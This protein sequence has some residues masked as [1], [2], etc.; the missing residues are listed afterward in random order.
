[1]AA[2]KPAR[3]EK[4]F[5]L[6]VDIGGT[7]TDVVLRRADGK[8]W[9]DKVLTTHHDLLE[10]LFRGVEQVLRKAK[11]G[12]AQVDDVV[13]HATTV[14]TNALIER[15][16]PKTALLTTNG[17]RD[18]LYIRDEYRYDMYDPQIEFPP[19][20][21]PHE[22]TFGVAE[23]TRA[24][25]T[26][27]KE[28]D[29]TE[30]RALAQTLRE[31]GVISV[32][33]CFL[34]AYRNPQN[35]RV[36][37]AA[38]RESAPELYVSLSSDVSPQIREYPRT[39]TTVIN[40]Y[41]APIAGPYLTRMAA[42]LRERGFVNAP[43][44]MLSNGGVIGVSVAGRFPVRMIESGPAAGALAASYYADTL[45][46]DRLL[47]FDMG[48][49]TAKACL[50]EN[51]APFVSGFFEVDRKYRFK[52]GSGY[53]VTIPSVDMIEIGA[54]G[55]SI[56]T[57]D[58]LNLLKVGPQ[59][60]GSMPGPVCYGHGGQDICVTDADLAL[61]LLDADHFLGGEMKLDVG[62][63]RARLTTL[64]GELGV[65]PADA[66]AGIYRIVGETMASAARAHAV[67][68]GVDYRGIPLLAFGGAGPLHACYVAGLLGSTTVIVPPN[69]SVLSAFGMLVTPVRYDLVRGA[70]GKLE[71]IDWSV[72]DSTFE[73]MTTAGR[74]ALL[75][76]GVPGGE[77][78][79]SFGGDLRYYGQAHEVTVTFDGDPRAG[80]DLAPI[81]ENFERVYEAQYGLRLKDNEVEVVNWRVTC[82]GPSILRGAAPQIASRRG[83]ARTTRSVHLGSGRTQDIRYAV[84]ERNALAA[85]QDVPGPAIIEERETTTVILPG[86]TARVDRTG[87][88]I[89]QHTSAQDSTAA[90][91]TPSVVPA[92]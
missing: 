21:V 9:V 16:G 79:F 84:Y 83:A 37:A 43:M 22:L 87:C 63:M 34:N 82:A 49:T 3:A 12:P 57:C 56:A 60:A 20:L 53:P 61:G 86:W 77:I 19:P 1:M 7:F 10:A 42:M 11:I 52:A 47:A 40:A 15:K 73:D 13:V 44:V 38:L 54:G 46:L 39:S 91:A 80:R 23:R 45:G 70:L 8:I 71:A 78:R 18:V 81:R 4:N 33:V 64:A 29:P 48:G 30:V 58:A 62:A 25:G 59:S 31:R 26:V 65:A 89:A 32:A 50:I 55:G 35:E 68:R 5:A 75:E 28:V 69:A 17:F 76:A 24:D 51:G 27:T 67:D 74:K 88:I 2:A 14:V 6:A 90:H 41:T 92:S 72:A 66:A 36:A 85:D